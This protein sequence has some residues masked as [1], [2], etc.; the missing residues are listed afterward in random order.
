[1]CAC[2]TFFSCLHPHFVLIHDKVK[3]NNNSYLILWI[4][5]TFLV[6]VLLL[7]LVCTV[8]PKMFAL[9]VPITCNVMVAGNRTLVSFCCCCRF[10]W[11]FWNLIKCTS[12]GWQNV[13]TAN[14]ICEFNALVVVIAVRRR[15]QFLHRHRHRNRCFRLRHRFT[16]R[17]R[18]FQFSI[19]S[20][21]SILFTSSHNP[22]WQKILDLEFHRFMFVAREPSRYSRILSMKKYMLS[23]YT[24]ARNHAHT[25]TY[26]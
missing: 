14:W 26:M 11:F 21:A 18:D 19:P 7:L 9:I 24:L 8:F 15:R 12:V 13:L 23:T 5:M 3:C 1:M 6:F 10:P 4:R 17:C 2:V 22:K 25:Y 16:T 20:A